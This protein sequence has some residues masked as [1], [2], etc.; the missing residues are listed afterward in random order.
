MSRN[1]LAVLALC[2]CVF[3]AQGKDILSST[4]WRI[5]GSG[6]A[7]GKAVKN[8]DGV[9]FT[10][11]GEKGL[12]WYYNRGGEYPL[13]PGKVYRIGVAYEGNLP[14][15]IMVEVIGA[16]RRPFPAAQGKDG[17]AEVAFIARPG[18]TRARIAFGL[19]A[20]GAVTIR[21]IYAEEMD[22]PENLLLNPALM[23][24]TVDV[25]GAKGKLLKIGNGYAVEKTVDGGYTAFVPAADLDIVPGKHYTVK[26]TLKRLDAKISGRLLFRMIGGKRTPFPSVPSAGA[27]DE[28]EELTY[29]FTALPGETKLRPHVIVTGQGTLEILGVTVKEIS[30][31]ELKSVIESRKVRK[32]SFEGAAIR[33]SW[34]INGTAGGDASR[35]FVEFTAG[36]GGG[37]VCDDLCWNASEIKSVEVECRIADEGGYLDCAFTSAENGRTYRSNRGFSVL[38][39]GQW[40]RIMFPVGKDPAWRGTIT[41]MKITWHGKTAPLAFRSI[42]AEKKIN[43]MYD[44]RPR[45]RYTLSR[46]EGKATAELRFLDRHYREIGKVELPAGTPSVDFIM[47]E[48]AMTVRRVPEN[49]LLHAD[50]RLLPKLDRPAAYWRGSWIWC[51]NNFGP[52]A[53]NVWFLREFD[54]DAVPDEAELLVAGDDSFQAFVNGREVG[55]GADWSIP[56]KFD[57]KKHLKAGRNRLVIRVYNAQAWGGL[58]CELYASVNGKAHYVVSDGNWR[59]HIGGKSEPG[60][61]DRKAM[62][63]G[64]P[65]IAPW[66]TRVGYR[67]IGPK[68]KIRVLKA[69]ENE[70]SAE[71]LKEV[72]LKTDKLELKL[73]GTGGAERRVTGRIVPGTGAWKK[74]EKIDVQIA[75][76]KQFAP[77]KIYSLGEF[78]TVEN[79]AALGTVKV[80]PETVPAITTAK[81]AGT[82]VRPYFTIGGKQYAPVYFLL[83]GRFGHS[84]ESRDWMIRNA[85]TADCKIMR[86]GASFGEFWK[87]KDD[88]DFSG[89]DRRLETVAFCA[90]ETKV[91]INVNA[92]MPLWWLKENPDDMTA[93]FGGKPPHRQKDRQAL[94]SKK[95]LEDARTGL[96]ALIRHLRKSPYADTVI[97]LALSEGWNGEWFWSYADD[98]QRFAMAGYSPADHA[99]FRSYLKERY[100]TDA[101]LRKAWNMPDVTLDKAPM[102]TDKEWGKGNVGILLDPEKDMPLIDW[103]RFRSRSLG[104]AITTLARYVKEET[105]G[106]WLAGAYYGYFLAFSNIFN[107]LQTVGHLDIE[108]VARSP[109]VD[110]LTGPSFYTWR[111]PGEADGIMQMAESFTAH[112]KLVIVE[113]DLRT[114]GETSNYEIRGGMQS[115]PE[116][117]VGAIDRAIAL[118]MTRGVGTHWFE[119]YENWFREPLLLQV[120]KE[121][122]KAYEALGPV[123]GTTPIETALVSDPESAMFVQLNMGNG[124]HV[125]SVG[126]MQRRFPEAAVPFRQVL[127]RDLLEKSVVP[128]HKFY[129]VNDLV[130]LNEADREALMKRFEREKATVLWLYAAGVTTPE[131]GPS[132]EKM[133]AFLGISFKM[134]NAAARPKLALKPGFGA[135]TAVN[136]N[137]S[138]PWFIPASGFE[139]VIGTLPDGSPGLVKWRRN[140][141]THYFSTLMNLPPALLRSLAEKAG[142]HVYTRT[143]D[144]VLVGNDVVALH[145]KSGGAKSIVLPRG[146]VMR[147][148]LGPIEGKYRSGEK[149]ETRPGQTYVFHVVKQQ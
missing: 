53:E 95:W 121:G 136:F 52:D 78:L 94:A 135:E 68:G 23:W 83:G 93:Y 99:T 65:P 130:T 129:I 73:A 126:E 72:P 49:A 91:I 56:G 37:L 11:T 14:T 148:V 4:Q 137:T 98:K 30:D 124:L 132:A 80:M 28:K 41:S 22:P 138:G 17:V 10:R 139:E 114:F 61:F 89:V 88:F 85:R 47:P 8:A 24:R 26:I 102:P 77:A 141:V 1:L 12:L 87:S 140:G 59:C 67:Y 6:G 76:P 100:K 142:V 25:G 15:R 125:A 50:L 118:A 120:M 134:E 9:V 96:R 113:Q 20:E 117:S 84:P 112:G 119:M 36:Q 81:V 111:F 57:V 116:Q 128:A 38:P 2:G 75:M 55:Q 29:T 101:A 13:I 115:T 110:F 54:L 51:W 66:S 45:G 19:Q 123:K 58:L 48:M 133:S 63:L 143:G 107:R 108:R 92:A 106:K 27:V 3:A 21:K 42:R 122:K 127:L 39:D 147:A 35:P 86:F 18:E 109:Y 97:G 5:T 90:P 16:N 64:V 71:V 43:H 33:R 40:H 104:E 62:E 74:G 7:A 146:T 131:K 79:D 46:I 60:V 105:D 149:F 103:F 70:F 145:A 34:R 144:P 82:G 44:L 69:G 31:E 32:K